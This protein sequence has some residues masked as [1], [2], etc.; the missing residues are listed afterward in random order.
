MH[1]KFMVNRTL[2][3]YSQNTTHLAVISYKLCAVAGIDLCRAE[4]TRLDTHFIELFD[5]CKEKQHEEFFTLATSKRG[6]DKRQSLI[7]GY[8]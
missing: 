2:S 4:V 5:E 8:V 7:W 6:G 1:G 3:N